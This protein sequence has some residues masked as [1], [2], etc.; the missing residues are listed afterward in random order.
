MDRAIDLHTSVKN[1]G[2]IPDAIDTDRD[3]IFGGNGNLGGTILVPDGQWTP[4]L[5]YGE[6]QYNFGFDTMACVSFGTLS[7]CEILLNRM[8]EVT[9]NFSDRFLAKA[10]LTTPQGNSPQK[11][12]EALR[13]LGVPREK[14]YPI[15]Q[16]LTSWEKFYAA[17]PTGI[18]DLAEQFLTLFA[19]N[20]EYVPTSKSSLKSALKYSPVGIAVSAWATNENGL[21]VSNFPNNHWTVLVGYKEGE[22]WIA[23]DSY[24]SFDGTF[25]KHL[26]WDHEFSQAKRYA[27]NLK[28]QTVQAV[29]YVLVLNN[30][31]SFFGNFW[32]IWRK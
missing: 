30:L 17:L 20:H 23:Y 18:I 26:A 29:W 3:Y 22:Y 1:Y 4:W 27:I 7:A 15:S 6:S 9:E 24:A 13:K 32:N 31:T 5:P 8:Y 28:D 10:S 16:D 19:F 12:A 14:D 21:Y 11:V 25:I 2:Y